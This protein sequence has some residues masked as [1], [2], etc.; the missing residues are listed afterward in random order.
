MLPGSLPLWTALLAIGVLGERIGRARALGLVL[1]VAG[2][3]LVGGA[4]LLRAFE[5]GEVWKGDLLFMAAAVSD[6]SASA[7]QAS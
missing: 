5:G 7:V 1:I 2:D 3:L 6:L 4:S